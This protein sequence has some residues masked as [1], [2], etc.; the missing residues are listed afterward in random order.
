MRFWDNLLQHDFLQWTFLTDLVW[1][2]NGTTL[3]CSF[4]IIYHLSKQSSIDFTA[5]CFTRPPHVLSQAIP[6]YP[7]N[8]AC[9]HQVMDN[10]SLFF[11]FR[12]LM[13]STHNPLQDW[14]NS[15]VLHT[16]VTTTESCLPNYHLLLQHNVYTALLTLKGR[17]IQ[18]WLA[19]VLVG[20]HGGPYSEQEVELKSSWGCLRPELFC[21]SVI[22]W[23][24]LKGVI[25]LWQ[26]IFLL[27]SVVENN[28]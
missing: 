12:F 13:P 6:S 1:G 26:I 2:G 8:S 16:T 9:F 10:T 23:Y 21:Y 20:F 5:S 27:C 3:L 11:H 28:H 19:P 15:C 4:F 7:A 22:K 14:Y 18:E 25:T 24:W 17:L